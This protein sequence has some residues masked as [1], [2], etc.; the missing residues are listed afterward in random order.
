MDCSPWGRKELDTTERLSLST[1]RVQ[2]QTRPILE[3]ETEA[4][5][6]KCLSSQR[7]W[8]ELKSI[9]RPSSE[10]VWARFSC[11]FFFFFFLATGA[12]LVKRTKKYILQK[13]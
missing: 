13:S 4:S 6:G 2:A 1:F 7:S 9:S 11:F 10:R 8:L 12:Q 3:E 5:G